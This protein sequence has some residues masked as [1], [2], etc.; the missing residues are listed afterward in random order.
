MVAEEVADVRDPR[1]ERTDLTYGNM[2]VKLSDYIGQV[3]ECKADRSHYW[4]T[5][6]RAREERDS[7]DRQFGGEVEIQ[8][9]KFS[10]IRTSSLAFPARLAR[11]A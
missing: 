11:L 3:F 5:V 7:R 2:R 10:E 1:A 6:V 8:N 9:S 4:R